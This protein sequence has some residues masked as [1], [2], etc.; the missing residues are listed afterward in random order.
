[1]CLIDKVV[2]RKISFSFLLQ[3]LHLLRDYGNIHGVDMHKFSG[4]LDGL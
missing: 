2:E 1:M 3:G 4:L